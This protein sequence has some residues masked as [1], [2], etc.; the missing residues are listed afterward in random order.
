MGFIV[1]ILV[2]PIK[3]EVIEFIS[4]AFQVVVVINLVVRAGLI[5]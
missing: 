2:M 3:D 5:I 1:S 4:R